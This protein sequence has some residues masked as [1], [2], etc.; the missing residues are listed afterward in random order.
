[1]SIL[2]RGSYIANAWDSLALIGALAISR[3]L[4]SELNVVARVRWPND[5]LV[6]DR[7]L[8]GVLVE[9]KSKGNEPDYALLGMGVNANFPR[10]IIR[11]A[12]PFSTTLQDLL[13]HPIGREAIICAIL[14]ETENLV[15]LMLS[16]GPSGI[17]ELLEKVECS[18]GKSVKVK[19]QDRE[20][21]GVF[22]GYDGLA[23]IRLA[24]GS[25]LLETVETSSVV[26]AE[27]TGA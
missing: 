12:A 2:L 7:K 5:V 14:S 18:R 13:G 21:S 19:L 1:M 17:L 6:D 20:I 22:D 23:R 24:T 15:D 26:L 3:S 8:S 27:Y 9:A 11:D 10:N 16:R 4:I 25:G